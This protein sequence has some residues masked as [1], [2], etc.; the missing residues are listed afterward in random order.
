MKTA[1]VPT[2]R[3]WYAHL[4]TRGEFRAH[5]AGG[6]RIWRRG[7]SFASGRAFAK[8]GGREVSRRNETPTS[9]AE[10]T[11]AV[12]GTV[13]A[14]SWSGLARPFGTTREYRSPLNA[15]KRAYPRLSHSVHALS[16]GRQHRAF[17][18]PISTNAWLA[19]SIQRSR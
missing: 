4:A 12:T 5:N 8:A 7:R 14:I 13:D 6:T 2:W 19:S 1:S 9:V 11:S 3:R 16:T 18:F 15:G 10:A 17:A